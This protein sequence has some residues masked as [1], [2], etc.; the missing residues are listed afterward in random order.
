MLMAVPQQCDIAD[1]YRMLSS[2]DVPC[3]LDV[4]EKWEFDICAM[5]GAVHIPLS[6]LQSR[7]Q[8]LP[9]DRHIVVVCHHGMRSL[10]GMSFLRAAGFPSAVSMRG[11]IDAW[12]KNIDR[13]MATY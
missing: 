11:G 10:K 9:Q 5:P 1:V 6:E 7:V 12:A 2:D 3:I 8:E 13:T 4:R